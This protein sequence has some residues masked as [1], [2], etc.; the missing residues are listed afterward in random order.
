VLLGF[1]ARTAAATN[2]VVVTLPSFSAFIAH[3]PEARFDWILFGLTTLASIVGA[4]LGATFMA[5]R[6]KSLTLTRVF[7]VALVLLAA[8]R[9]FALVV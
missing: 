9:V 7:A 1:A 3:L 8:Q 5:N 4:Q 6:V 2:S